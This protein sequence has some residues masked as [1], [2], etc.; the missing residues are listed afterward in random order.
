MTVNI[1][2]AQPD[3]APGILAIYGPY[4]EATPVTFEIVPPTLDDMVGR[5]NRITADYPWLVAE[6][7]GRVAGYVY[8]TKLRERA[9]YRWVVEVAAY[10]APDIQRR[11]LGRILYT[12][13]FSILRIQGFFKAFASVTLPN[14]SS[15]GLHESLGFRS[16]STFRGVGFKDGRWL[17]VGWWQLDLQPEIDSPPEPQTF[18]AIRHSEAVTAALQVGARL[19]SR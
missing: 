8:A 14:P 10:V 15:V 7:D 13:L 5:I 2:L 17:D 18:S 3:D 19:A 4:C 11:G 1:R 12:T 9:A 6:I 16:S